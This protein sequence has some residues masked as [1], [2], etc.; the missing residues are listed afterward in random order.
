VGSVSYKDLIVWKKSMQLAAQIYKITKTFPKEELY[1]LTSQMRRAAVSIPS[2]IA[3]GQKRN[4]K[5]EFLQ[6][7]A[8]AKGSLAEL[9]TQLLLSAE[10]NYFSNYDIIEVQDLVVEI[11]KML[12]ALARTL[13]QNLKLETKN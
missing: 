7:L 3:E 1:G 4:S 12:N 2:N 8:V 10:I 11:E 13:S 9:E 5:K 6:F